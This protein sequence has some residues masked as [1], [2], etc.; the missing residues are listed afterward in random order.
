MAR[1]FGKGILVLVRS[2]RKRLVPAAAV[3]AVAMMVMSPG[4]ATADPRPTAAQ[5]RARLAKLQDQADKTVDRYNAVIEDYKAAKKKYGTLDRQLSFESSKIDTLRDDVATAASSMYQFGDMASLP[6]VISKDDP[7][8]LLAGL[9]VADQV[10]AG[11]ARTLSAFDEATRDLRARRGKAKA[12]YDDLAER[13]T[14]VTEQKKQVEKLIGEQEQLLRRLN[15]FNPGN[16]NSRGIKYTG[17]ASGSAKTV[18][19]F[20][21][22]QVGKPYRYGA[23]GPNAFDCSG[24]A[25]AAWAKAGVHL[26]R[27]TYAQWAWGAKRRVS[28]NA[29][30]PG[31]LLFSNG[32]SHMGI[33]AGE[34]KML[35][36]PHTGDV[37][38]VV[39]LAGY[40]STRL[41]GAIRP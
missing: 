36:A 27:T 26:P 31:D 1:P 34:G 19:Q 29:L 15:Q 3:L 18:L 7:A 21:F 5:A 32:L 24:F 25:Q 6:T 8:G 38:R 40:W 39:A 22:A 4:S 17:T 23:T 37:V 12:A 16:P 28:L 13:L 9:A 33:Y 41:V 20:A 10:T 2:V 30:Q 14:G 35:H 11:Q